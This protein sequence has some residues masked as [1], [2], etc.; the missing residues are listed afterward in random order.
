M[1]KDIID[2]IE[3]IN[4]NVHKDFNNTIINAT[5]KYDIY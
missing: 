5:N 1:K 2:N 4:K 3:I